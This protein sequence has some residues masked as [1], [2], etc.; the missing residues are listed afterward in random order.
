MARAGDVEVHIASNF[1]F[2]VNTEQSICV[3]VECREHE[4]QKK[5]LKK[6]GRGPRRHAVE[7]CA[8]MFWAENT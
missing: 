1:T 5:T 4:G 6:R 7:R 2:T 8:L 3:L